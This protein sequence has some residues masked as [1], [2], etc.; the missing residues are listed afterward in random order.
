MEIKERFGNDG[1]RCSIKYLKDGSG[2]LGMYIIALK[3]Y[4]YVQGIFK[5]TCQII[6]VPF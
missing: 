6:F 5:K 2:K 4:T 3:K 1:G